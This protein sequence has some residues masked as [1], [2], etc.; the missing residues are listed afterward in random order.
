M[1]VRMGALSL[2]RR[3]FGVMK[4]NG[5]THVLS[6]GTIAISFFLFAA[7]LLL[8]LNFA[9]FLEAWEKKVQIILYLKDGVEAKRILQLTGE[10]QREEGIREVSYVSQ[11]KAMESFE[12]DL[13]GYGGVLKGLKEEVF[14][15]SFEIQMDE[16]FRTPERIR[17]L[18][19]RLGN[20]KEVEEVQYGG[21]WLER[22]SIFLYTLKWGLWILGG[23]LVVIIVSVTA[24]TV[25][26]TLYNK[27]S[28]IEI[29]KLVGA[30]DTFVKLPFY[31]EG[32]LQGF[33]GAA[34]SILLLLVLFHF[35]SLKVSPYVS[36]YFG[37]LRLSFLPPN[38]IGWIL[39]IGVASGLLGGLLSLRKAARI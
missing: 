29:L 12:R 23:V 25:R 13:A 22:F 1:K 34:G 10:L 7:F 26:L 8:P 2:V 32:G 21:V 27:K 5:P 35:F 39:G 16:R 28:E 19:A 3:T 20:I 17:A 11:R 4:E 15:A 6:I 18:A 31:L 30:T 37:Q 14:P 36:L 38:M 9:S 33:L 24:N